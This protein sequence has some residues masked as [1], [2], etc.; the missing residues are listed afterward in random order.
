LHAGY[1]GRHEDGAPLI[2][3]EF[4]VV[5]RRRAG[6]PRR[7][8]GRF[9]VVFGLAAASPRPPWPEQVS[10]HRRDGGRATIDAMTGTAVTPAGSV[11]WAWATGDDQARDRKSGRETTEDANSDV[12]QTRQLPDHVQPPRG[13]ALR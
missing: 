3:P 4:E 9:V 11:S 6:L 10:A 5:R 13:C 2:D 1:V 8:D 12:A 7:H